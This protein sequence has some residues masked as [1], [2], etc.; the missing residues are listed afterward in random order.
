MRLFLAVLTL[1]L[2]ASIAHAQDA[3]V[4]A[5]N[6]APFAANAESFWDRFWDLRLA[7]KELW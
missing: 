2:M 4:A 1:A 6:A 7:V 3:Q 5:P